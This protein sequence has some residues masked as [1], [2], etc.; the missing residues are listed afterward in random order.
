M[1]SIVALRLQVKKWLGVRLQHQAPPKK[2][3]D[4]L[5]EASREHG[6]LQLP[7]LPDSVGYNASMLAYTASA[8]M[9][10]L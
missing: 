10:V 4:L 1:W 9:P 3:I 6:C 2:Q 7:S 5:G 8:G